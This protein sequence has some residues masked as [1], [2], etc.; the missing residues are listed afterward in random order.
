MAAWLDRTVDR[1]DR[2]SL[3]ALLFANG[4]LCLF[5]LLAHGGALLLVRSGKPNVFGAAF[6][7][8]YLSIPVACVSILLALLAWLAPRTREVVLRVH[9]FVLGCLAAL[10]VWFAVDV[11][12]TGV[13]RTAEF[14]WNPLF[15]AFLVGY[16]VYLVRR[17]LVSPAVLERPPFRY[18]HVIAV[19]VSLLLSALV[20]WR[21]YEAAAP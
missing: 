13:P 20:Y 18:A 8:V 2:V 7:L 10:A 15:F 5:V 9:T 16:P 14:V 6:E 12:A 1:L 4:L 3:S 21:I 17:S 11:I 19:A